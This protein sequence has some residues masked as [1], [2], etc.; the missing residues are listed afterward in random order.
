MNNIYRFIYLIRLFLIITLIC[1]ILKAH[2]AGTEENF[3][4]ISAEGVRPLRQRVS[5]ID[6]K[7]SE[8]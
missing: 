5:K 2:S 1:L 8:L 7:Q 6:T 4:C 3:D